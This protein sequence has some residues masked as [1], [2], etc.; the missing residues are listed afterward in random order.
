[1]RPRDPHD[2]DKDLNGDLN[3]D[4]NDDPVERLLRETLTREADMVRPG[5]DGLDRIT[6]RLDADGA[7]SGQQGGGRWKPWGAALVAAA[8]VGVVVGLVFTTTGGDV[9]PVAGPSPSISA[10]DSG[11]T[12]PSPTSSQT[13]A[14][15]GELSGVPVY[16]LGSSKASVWLFR[17]FR[18][19]PDVG[20][21]VASAVSAMTA[22]EPQDP[23]YFTPWSP[24]SR[25]TASVDGEAIKVDLSADAF[26]GPGVGSEVA[27]QAVQ[28]LVWTATAAAQTGGPVTV[29]VDGEAYDAW[30]VMSLG[31]PMERDPGARAFIW[32]DT[33]EEGA[34]Y[35]SDGVDVTGSSSTWEG[36]VSWDV[37]ADD[38]RVVGHGFTNGGANGP[39][40]EY[41]FDLDMENLAPGGPYTLRLW[42]DDVSDGESPEGPRMFEQTRTFFV[43]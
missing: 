11:T 26:A 4:L 38:G 15:G 43:E 10:T 33:P 19:V 8:V 34:T 21:E 37:V 18:T 3:G 17:E 5:D 29:T 23:D 25:V 20:G 13:S 32:I 27:E 41:A 42:E 22:L 36:T 28:Q 9:D 39:F 2:L 6:E 14:P 16:W 35:P 30:G 24:A 12:S 1:M 31:E 40:D 7:G